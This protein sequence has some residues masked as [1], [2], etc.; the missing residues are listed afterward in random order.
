[1]FFI[2]CQSDCPTVP[3][4]VACI[5][6]FCRLHVGCQYSDFGSFHIVYIYMFY[7]Q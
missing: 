4:T 2:S 5:Y 3:P 7:S 1:M 6:M